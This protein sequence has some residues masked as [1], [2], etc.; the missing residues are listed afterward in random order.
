MKTFLT[1]GAAAIALA[2]CGAPSIAFAQ[3]GITLTAEQ[4]ADFAAWSAAQQTAYNAWTGDLQTYYWGLTPSQRTAWW[5]LS[6]E[7]RA[8]LYAWPSDIRSYYWGLG[9]VDM[10]SWWSLTDAQRVAVYG[11]VP[12]ARDYYWTLTPEQRTGWWALNDAQ[13]TRLLGLDAEGRTKAWAA[14]GNQMS[15]RSPVANAATTEARMDDRAPGD[16]ADAVAA[17]KTY[18]VCS[19]TIQDSCIQ[20]RAAGKNYGNRPLDY[21][22]GAPASELKAK[23][24]S[25]GAVKAQAKVKAKRR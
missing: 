12:E 17:A 3:T 11:W 9:P 14:I 7:Q 18:P 13:R 2:L 20:P 19:A 25:T 15:N 8:G 16:V 10:S 5:M 23:G 21:W 4:Q 24:M 22:P 6:D 1:T